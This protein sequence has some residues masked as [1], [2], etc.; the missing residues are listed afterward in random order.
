M[1]VSFHKQIKIHR[2]MVWLYATYIMRKIKIDKYVISGSY[3]RGKRWSNDMDILVPINK[4]S[5]IDAIKKKLIDAGW[6]YLAYRQ[7]DENLLGYQ[8]IKKINLKTIVLDMFFS[9]PETWGNCLLFTTGS[10]KFNDKIRESLKERGMSWENPR[11]FKHTESGQKYS[12]YTE[13]E[14]LDFLGIKYVEPKNRTH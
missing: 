14:A 11:Y 8:F 1:S 12:F 9:T 4:I 7:A 6:Q 3:V 5:E 2:W 13:K 10:K